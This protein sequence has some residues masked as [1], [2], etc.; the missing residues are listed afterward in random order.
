VMNTRQN[1]K[2]I[3]FGSKFLVV[4]FRRL[5]IED[6]GAGSSTNLENHTTPPAPPCRIVVF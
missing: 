6:S 3:V 5:K 1:S 2:I 4:G